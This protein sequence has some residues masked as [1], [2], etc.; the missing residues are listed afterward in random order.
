MSHQKYTDYRHSNDHP[1]DLDASP[2]RVGPRLG[3][4]EVPPEVASKRAGL[5]RELLTFGFLGGGDPGDDA[6]EVL[7]ELRNGMDLK[8]VDGALDDLIHVGV[9]V[10][11]ALELS[12]LQAG[13]DREVVDAA[14]LFAAF[15]ALGNGHG[16]AYFEPL[17]PQAFIDAHIGERNGLYRFDG[18]GQ[19]T[20]GQAGTESQ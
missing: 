7:F 3:S 2:R 4:V 5:G 13:G 16:A 14:G 10:M 18:P 20:F 8:A 9:V 12:F 15:E 11:S 6:V 19:G 17:C 1:G